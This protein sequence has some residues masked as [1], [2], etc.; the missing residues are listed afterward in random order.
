[1]P[2]LN[3]NALRLLK[4]NIP[5]NCEHGVSMSRT[6]QMGLTEHSGIEYHSIEALLN[7]CS[8]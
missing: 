6:C 4:Q 3:A 7:H 5:S 8:G 2:E 1:M